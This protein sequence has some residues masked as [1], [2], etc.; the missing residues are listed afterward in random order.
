MTA[1]ERQP[2]TE[3]HVRIQDLPQNERPRER[4]LHAGAA[5]LSNSELLA[6]LIRTGT[7]GESALDLAARLLAARGLDGLQRASAAE[8]AE[9]HGLGDAKAAQLKAALEL[10]LRLA[11]LQP[12]ER[13]TISSPEDVMNLIGAEMAL[14]EQEELRVLLLTTKHQVIAVS[15]V[16]RGSVRAASVRIAEVL[17]DAIR[18]NSPAILAV[19]NHP[20]GD[21]APSEDDIAMTRELVAAG[22]L[23]DVDVVDHVIVGSG[24][25]H[26]SL[27]AQGLM[28]EPPR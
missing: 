4:L 13:P 28:T 6:I 15:T 24:G 27:R 3:Y 19:H 5:A 1:E 9:E 21:P 16:Y 17:R 25:R 2:R 20:S 23:L 8:L 18:R 14:L 7:R 10:G 26:S 11:A 12:E 22:E